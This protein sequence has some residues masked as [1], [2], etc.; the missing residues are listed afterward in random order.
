MPPTNTRH[1]VCKEA[2]AAVAATAGRLAGVVV[3]GT[4]LAD[5]LADMLLAAFRLVWVLP[6]AASI[7]P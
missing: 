3:A 5:P 6:S 7:T 1:L 4:L 2:L